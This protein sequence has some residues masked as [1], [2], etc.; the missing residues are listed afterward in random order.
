MVGIGLPGRIALSFLREA[1]SAQQAV[2]SALEDVNR[3]IPDAELIE[4]SPDLA[5]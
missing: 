5:G 4:A 2:I 3:A 1:D